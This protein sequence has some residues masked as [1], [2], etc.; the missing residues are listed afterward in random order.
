MVDMEVS[1]FGVFLFIITGALL[2]VIVMGVANVYRFV[3]LQNDYNISRK[4]YEMMA[5]SGDDLFAVKAKEIERRYRKNSKEEKPE[6]IPL[7]QALIE[8]INYIDSIGDLYYNYRLCLVLSG[9]A[10]THVTE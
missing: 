7:R 4:N 2:W 6:I 3:S 1:F 5:S 8:R 9:E 10:A